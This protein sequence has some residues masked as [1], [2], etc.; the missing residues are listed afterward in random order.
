[1][2]WGK[3]PLF[4]IFFE[5]GEVNFCTGSFEDHDVFHGLVMSSCI[6]GKGVVS[7]LGRRASK[8]LQLHE[9]LEISWNLF[10]ECCE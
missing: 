2:S 3:G 5:E 8:V 4:D 9:V 10:E 1:M 6:E 7:V